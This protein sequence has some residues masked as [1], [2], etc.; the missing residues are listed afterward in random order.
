MKKGSNVTDHNDNGN[1][2][3]SNEYDSSVDTSSSTSENDLIT[4]QENI[5]ASNI[6]IPTPATIIQLQARTSDQMPAQ[7]R[8]LISG[9]TKKRSIAECTTR[10]DM[11]SPRPHEVS[12]TKK[13][14]TG[15][16][17]NQTDAH[18]AISDPLATRTQSEI[19][20]DDECRKKTRLEELK[21]AVN[22]FAMKRNAK[23]LEWRH[24]SRGSFVDAD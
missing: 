23:I 7:T 15:V 11:V 17:I 21:L 4:Q 6:P 8:G 24:R 16:G 3:A 5:L 2:I 18:V 14:K 13:A 22:K 20:M 12:P 1:P 19:S 9:I 10:S